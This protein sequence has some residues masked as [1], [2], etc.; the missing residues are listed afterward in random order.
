MNFTAL[1]KI[2]LYFGYYYDFLF[3][4]FQFTVTF[5]FQD[6]FVELERDVFIFHFYD[7][8]I[9]LKW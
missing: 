4:F 7:H 2:R 9:I 5:C 8:F 3:I 6:I 1:E